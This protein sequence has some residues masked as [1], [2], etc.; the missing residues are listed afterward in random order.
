[1]KKIKYFLFS[2][3][4]LFSFSTVFAKNEIVIKDITPIYDENSG[5]IVTEENGE[6]SVI[7]NDKDQ[8]VKYKITIQNTFEYDVLIKKIELTTPTEEFL[9]YSFEGLNENNVLKS[10]ETKDVIVS[11]ETVEVDGWGRN[12]TDEL[13]ANISYEKVVINPNTSTKEEIVIWFL[14]AFITISTIVICK[15]NKVAQYVI[16]IITLSSTIPSINAQELP[17]LLIKINVSYESQNIMKPSNCELDSKSYKIS[18]CSDYWNYSQQ[19]KN[20]YIENESRDITDYAYKFDVS[21][22]QNGRVMAYL[23]DNED[24]DNYYNL[25][26]QADGL[27]YPNTNAS[28]YFS[29][30]RYLSVID[31]IEG[32]DTSNVTNM[33]GMFYYAGYK[34]PEFTL[35]LGNKFNT[36]KVE[37][38]SFMFAFVG[39]ESKVLTIDISNFNTSNVTDM[40]SMFQMTGYDCINFNLDLSSFN[41]IRVTNMSKMFSQTGQNSEKLILDL[42]NNFDTSNVTNMYFMFSNTGYESSEFILDL[43]DKFDTSKVTDMGGMFSSTGRN[44][45]TFTLD[46]GD[47][48]DTSNVTKMNSMFLAIGYSNP[49]FTLDLGDKFDTS[50]VTNMSGLF[51]ETGYN[52]KKFTLELGE[53][54][55]TSKVTNMSNLFYYTGYSNPEFTLDLGNKFDTSN[56]T[57]TSGM[58]RFSGHMSTK[59]DIHMTI[60]NPNVTRYSDMFYG[61]AHK[62][63]SKITVNYTKDTES[64]VEKMI[65]TKSGNCNVVKGALVE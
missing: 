13:T 51:W 20:I 60:R 30:M 39:K 52:S 18:G 64:L 40:N 47:K 61:T 5:V 28:Y 1:M 12:F 3:L 49:E 6:H 55:D 9:K 41:T 48:F 50:N 25:Y 24:D 42:G 8:S 38:M 56:V 10:K 62:T 21:E 53:N 63:G 45:P 17:V 34:N 27:I 16:L 11:L 19:I 58:F 37:D 22:K 14:V 44:N 35:D 57:D 23:I 26:L 33:K 59:L 29:D 15:K 65:A 43:G 46:L 2:I 36:S 31:N 54:F 4:C 32:L 7:F